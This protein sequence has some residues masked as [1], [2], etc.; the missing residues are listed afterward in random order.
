M[1]ALDQ[2]NLGF[3][4]I[5]AA[6]V[7]GHSIVDAWCELAT[8]LHNG[9]TP[10]VIDGALGCLLYCIV[11]LEKVEPLPGFED[12][13]LQQIFQ[14]G[15]TVRLAACSQALKSGDTKELHYLVCSMAGVLQPKTG[16]FSFFGNLP[17]VIPASK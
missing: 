11:A 17:S 10:Y 4:Q 15:H 13:R 3:S 12:P 2:V 7:G 1:M 16:R 5:R 14:G 8:M 6:V 9:K